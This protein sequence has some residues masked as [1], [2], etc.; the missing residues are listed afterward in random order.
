MTASSDT[1][2]PSTIAMHARYS[3]RATLA[4]TRGVPFMRLHRPKGATE[5]FQF[6]PPPGTSANPQKRVPEPAPTARKD[7][8]RLLRLH[9]ANAQKSKVFS[10]GRRKR[11][12]SAETLTATLSEPVYVVKPIGLKIPCGIGC[13]GRFEAAPSTQHFQP[14]WL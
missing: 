1:A 6:P 10:T 2:P 4:D 7:G 5:Q 11:L 9:T 8:R 3:R 12:L 14:V 13:R